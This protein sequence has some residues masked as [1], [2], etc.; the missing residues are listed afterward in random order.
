MSD[1]KKRTKEVLIEMLTE[2][3]G[4]NIFDSGGERNRGWQRNQYR[5]FEE[6]PEEI[7]VFDV[8]ESK[9]EIPNAC[10]S[11]YHALIDVISFDEEADEDYRRFTRGSKEPHPVDLLNF[12]RARL[13]DCTNLYGSYSDDFAHLSDHFNANSLTPKDKILSDFYDR[14]GELMALQF[15]LGCDIRSGWGSPRLFRLVDPG[16]IICAGRIT[17]AGCLDDI[18]ELEGHPATESREEWARSNSLCLLAP[19]GELV[20]PRDGWWASAED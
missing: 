14:E 18:Y 13:L 5:N 20:P 17:P 19:D 11:S 2:C 16:G 9:L 3:T 4:R 12:S 15:H 7:V 6:E 8:F 10:R 1:P